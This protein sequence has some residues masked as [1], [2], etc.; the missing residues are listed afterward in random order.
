MEPHLFHHFRRIHIAQ[1]DEDRFVQ[2]GFDPVEVQRPIFV[3]LGHED[4]GV[5]PITG[6]VGVGAILDARQ[7]PGGLRHGSRVMGPDQGTV[8]E[9]GRDDGKGRSVPNVIG[10]GLEGQAENSQGFPG[11]T[12]AEGNSDL[13]CHA[14]FLGGIDFD[15]GLDN[16]TGN[17]AFLRNAQ[18]R[19]GILGK[20]RTAITRPRMQKL[21]ANATIQPH[22]A[23]QILHVGPDF[24]TDV[25]QFIDEADLGRKKGVGGIFDEFRGLDGGDDKGRLDEIERAVDGLQHLLGHGRS[26]P[27]HHAIRMHE[28]TD[29]RPFAQKLGIAGHIERGFG[30][31]GRDDAG[32]LAAGANRHSALVHH[33]GVIPEVRSN[34]FGCF[35]DIAQIGIAIAPPGCGRPYGNEDHLGLGHAGGEFRRKN[36]T[37]GVH[38]LANDELE[39]RLIDRNFTL[40]QNTDLA[41]V[42]V[43]TRHLM[44][45]FGEASPAHKS[46]I[47]GSNDRNFHGALFPFPG[48]GDGNTRKL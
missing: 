14:R 1:I 20:A 26:D 27:D 32:H 41:L 46:N 13:S 35:V 4:Q 9:Q 24:L 25:C 5:G 7:E 10:F 12:A 3:P 42:L 15:N 47:T 29:S 39:A 36:E 37:P 8:F 34:L 45:E 21:L 44:T 2:Q 48:S 23:R 38:V 43:D 19:L 16:A 22:A 11:L 33:H 28:I 30:V 40:F 18:Q 17:P 31:G 6:F